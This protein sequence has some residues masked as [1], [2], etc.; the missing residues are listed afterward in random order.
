MSRHKDRWA[1]A[2][3][4]A[5]QNNPRHPSRRATVLATPPRWVSIVD[6]IEADAAALR[7]ARAKKRRAAAKKAADA[8]KAAGQA[9]AAERGI[10]A[11]KAFCEGNDWKLD[12]L[13][14]RKK[15]AAAE[16]LG[17]ST[18]TID[19]HLNVIFPEKKRRSPK[20]KGSSGARPK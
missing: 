17:V 14:P 13:N 5:A 12:K 19:R 15:T 18:R 16:A 6:Q 8:A 3:D 2:A 1:R 4:L 7:D 11:L 9:G 20:R 10:E